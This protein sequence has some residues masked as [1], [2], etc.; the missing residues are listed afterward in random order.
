MSIADPLVERMRG[1]GTTIF[2]E[3]SALAVRTGSINLGQGFPD[4]DG[5]AQLLRGR[6]RRDHRPPA[7]TSTRPVS[8]SRRCGRRSPPTSN[9]STA[10]TFDPDTEV[11]VTAGATEAIA[12]SLLAL[13]EPGD[14]VVVFEPYYDSY[15]ACIALGGARRRP[16]TLHR[17]GQRWTFDP[18]ELRRG[19][20]PADQGD[21]A[22]HAAQ[23]DRQGVRPRRARADRRPRPG[24]HDLI[25]IADEVYEHLTFDGRHT[26]RSPPCPACASAPSPSAAPARRS[27]SPAGRSAG[28]ARRR[29]AHER[30]AH[31][32]AVPHLRQ[33][34]DRSSPRSPRPSPCQT[35]TTRRIAATL[36]QP[37]RPALRRARRP[38][39]RR[40]PAAGHLLRHRRRRHATPSSSAASCRSEHGV[41]AIPSSVF[42]DSRRGRPPRPVRVLQASRGARRGAHPAEGSTRMKVA[43]IQHDIVWEDADATRKHSCR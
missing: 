41:V 27:A 39:L 25:V 42:Y 24:E 12:A 5:P 30:G 1:F 4:T 38:R 35:A 43:A 31:R 14:E 28:S 2:A 40:D 33:R 34:R 19:D 21:P 8:A 10:S 13:T 11:L 7:T 9:G 15:A 16:V 6:C 18:D 3:M 22:Q 17:D 26:S 29:A 20:H 23:P 37:A 36:Q 32:Q